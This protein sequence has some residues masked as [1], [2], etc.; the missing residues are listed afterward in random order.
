MVTISLV[1]ISNDNESTFWGRTVKHDRKV[2]N[3][4][5]RHQ[6]YINSVILIA[7]KILL[8]QISSVIAT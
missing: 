5:N 1:Y 3:F 6:L 8:L 4:M 2:S 7:A